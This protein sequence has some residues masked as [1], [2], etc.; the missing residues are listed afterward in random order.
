MY[1]NIL[2]IMQKE[3]NY[4]QIM[5]KEINY[6]QTLLVKTNILNKNILIFVFFSLK[7]IFG[8]SKKNQSQKHT[9]N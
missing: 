9:N 6:I 7:S 5:Q 2:Y 8:L 1:A 3:I 4:I